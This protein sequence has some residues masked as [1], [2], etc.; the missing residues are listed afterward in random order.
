MSPD[1]G[2]V[3]FKSPASILSCSGPYRPRSPARIGGLGPGV[4]KQARAAIEAGRATLDYPN[5]L[6]SLLD[7]AG[8]T[9]LVQITEQDG[10]Q[11]VPR[12]AML[13]YDAGGGLVDVPMSDLGGGLFEGTFGSMPCGQLVQFYVSAQ[14]LSNI[15]M[16]DP[17]N[18]PLAL[19]SVPSAIETTADIDATS[20]TGR[21]RS[22]SR[23]TCLAALIS[24]AGSVSP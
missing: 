22:S 6:P 18:A 5:G 14:T 21:F 12:T 19:H 9:I 2:R 13:H 10:Q 7:P 8:D 3:L 16:T 20:E 1:A 23:T 11:F 24:D 4:Q 15:T 17:P